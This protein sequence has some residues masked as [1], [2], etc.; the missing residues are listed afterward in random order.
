MF[1]LLVG[2]LAVLVAPGCRH[3]A[4][5]HATSVTKPQM[6]RLVQPEIRTIVRV[7]GQPSFTQS[8]E[9]SSVYPKMNAY[10]KK[11]IVDIGDKVKKGDVLA[12]LFVPEL[13]ED[14]VTKKATVALDQERIALAKVV[15]EVAQ[16]D[17]EA[18]VARVEEARAEFD[19]ARFEAERWDSETKRLENELKR[20]VVNPQDVLQTTNR[21][22]ASVALR[23]T[24][25]ATVLKADAELLSRRAALAQARVDVRVAEADL[26][27]AE[28]EEK[29]LKAWV[30]YLI[31]P[32]PFDGVIVARNANTFDFV[33]PTTGDPSAYRR[34]PYLSP[35]GTAAPIYVV[36]R[37][38]I[39]RVFVDIPEKYA[40]YVQPGSKAT[41]LIKAY[42]NQP[43]ASTVTRTS[44]ALNIQSRTLRAEVDLPNVGSQLLPGMYAF[45]KVTIE[46]PGVHAL[47]VSALMHLGEKTILQVGEKAFC[48]M[49]EDGHANRI[50][51]Q[52]GIS[53]GEWIEVT[54]RRAP[55][56]NAASTG[57]LAWTPIDG[58]EKMILGNLSILNEGGRVTV[59]P[60]SDSTKTAAGAPGRRP[61]N[62]EP[63]TRHLSR[64]VHRVT[65]RAQ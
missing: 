9:R 33:L 25:A 52:T 8:Y 55:G 56:D 12:T 10:I 44:W 62:A 48:W 59:A 49:Y 16:A 40:D 11:W 2:L 61:A 7:V 57:D 47:P 28:S 65:G 58:T 21:W 51:V 29:R 38:D 43:I 45:A 24:A 6:V 60:A 31:L 63:T 20:G 34:G 53:D 37:T 15:V 4:E 39:I 36:D 23:D 17:V 42:R 54:N 18:A 35:S 26:K 64:Q 27:M 14:H 22:K 13:V 30:D 32:A 1:R 5:S 46:R 41:V 3:E 50:E 19:G